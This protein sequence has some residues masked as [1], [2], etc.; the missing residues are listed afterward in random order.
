MSSR[1]VI[2]LILVA[3]AVCSTLV[4]PRP[5]REVDDAFLPIIAEALVDMNRQIQVPEDLALIVEKARKKLKRESQRN[6][7]ERLGPIWG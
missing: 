6:R 5:M 1:F 3:L 7:W 4:A 2:S